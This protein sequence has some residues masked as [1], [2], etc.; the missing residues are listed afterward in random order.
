[1]LP[2]CFDHF[3]CQSVDG[4]PAGIVALKSVTVRYSC[5]FA[6]ADTS[7]AFSRQTILFVLALHHLIGEAAFEEVE[8]QTVHRYQLG[9]EHGFQ[10]FLSVE[11]ISKHKASSFTRVGVQVH[12]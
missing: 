4:A 2:R 5:E 1:M 12:I 6:D 9:Q 7:T 10:S 8:V 11:T 3:W